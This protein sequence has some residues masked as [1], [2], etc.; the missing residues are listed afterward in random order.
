MPGAT[1]PDGEAVRGRG[2]Y[3]LGDLAASAGTGDSGGDVM[4]EMPEIIRG[5]RE[6]FRVGREFRSAGRL[7]F[8][9]RCRDLRQHQP[10]IPHK[11]QA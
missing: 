4:D 11:N 3:Y 5:C 8:V 7:Q 6:C 1:S 10:R 2:A 9:P